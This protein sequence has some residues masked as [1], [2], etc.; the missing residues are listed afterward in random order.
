MLDSMAV[1]SVSSRSMNTID[2]STSHLR[3][4]A[5]RAYKDVTQADL[6]FALGVSRQTVIRKEAGGAFTTGDLTTIAQALGISDAALLGETPDE[7]A[8]RARSEADSAAARNHA[9]T[10]A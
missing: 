3:V 2:L 6:A 1:L 7:A 8:A 9:E 5:W 10:S 4:K